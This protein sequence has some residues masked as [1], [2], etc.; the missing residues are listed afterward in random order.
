MALD[1]GFVE[2]MSEMA[3][4]VA[5]FSALMFALRRAEGPRALFR[6]HAC[7]ASSFL[8]LAIALA[9][10]LLDRVGVGAERVWPLSNA[11]CVLLAGPFTAIML[12]RS[13]TLTRLGFPP[14]AG[15]RIY[16]I[17]AY[18]CGTATTAIALAS[19]APGWWGAASA[20][21]FAHFADAYLA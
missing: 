21:G 7:V 3:V 14:Q 4:A 20:S 6:A 19:F 2:V 1:F 13:R 15:S 8:V 9:P 16:P 5:G 18:G 12:A 10:Q 11:I 17:I